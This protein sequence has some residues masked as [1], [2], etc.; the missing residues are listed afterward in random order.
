MQRIGVLL[1]LIVS[2]PLL[3]WWVLLIYAICYIF[4]YKD[5][6]EVVIPAL[7]FDALYMVPHGVHIFPSLLIMVVLVFSMKFVRPHIAFFSE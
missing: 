1:I 2:V 4:F 7:F 6:Y 3:P 5:P